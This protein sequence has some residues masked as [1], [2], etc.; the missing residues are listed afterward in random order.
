LGDPLKGNLLLFYKPFCIVSVGLFERD[1]FDLFLPEFNKP[2]VIHLRETCCCST[3][4]Y[5]WRPNTVYKNRRV[6]R[7]QGVGACQRRWWRRGAGASEGTGSG[8][9]VG[10]P[11]HRRAPAVMV[12]S[13]CRGVGGHRRCAVA[14]EGRVPAAVVALEGAGGGG[15]VG[16]RRRRWWHRRV[17]AWATAAGPRFR[18]KLAL[19]PPRLRLLCLDRDGEDRGG[20]RVYITR[21]L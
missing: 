10:V 18:S 11:G 20:A 2:W 13:V 21:D 1:S 15:G 8:G 5:T 14:S 12:A 3:N 16:G 6:R 4:L 9:G 7:H 17:E 19:E